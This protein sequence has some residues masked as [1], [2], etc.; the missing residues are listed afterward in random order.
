VTVDEPGHQ[1][2]AAQRD[3]T[4]AGRHRDTCGRTG[5]LDVTTADDNNPPRL[6]GLPVEHPV[7]DERDRRSRILSRQ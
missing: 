2:H 6:A 3:R 5:S 7:G 1:R 4:R